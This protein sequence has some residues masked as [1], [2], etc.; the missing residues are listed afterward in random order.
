MS[1]FAKF[2]YVIFLVVGCPV[3]AVLMYENM[4]PPIPLGNSFLHEAPDLTEAELD[5]RTFDFYPYTGWHIQE[6]IHHKG[7]LKGEEQGYD[8]DLKSGSLGFFIDFDLLN[9]PEKEENEY[10][11][12]L[13]GGSGAQGWGGQSNE[14]MFYQKL[15]KKL[16][17]SPALQ[18]RKITVIN[19]AMAGS[20]SYQNFLALNK[21]GHQLEPDLIVSYS[22]V[23]DLDVPIAN[24]SDSYLRFNQLAGL[25]YLVRGSEYPASLKW[26]VSLFPRTLNRTGIGHALKMLISSNYFTELAKQRNMKTF[27]NEGL[28]IRGKV[29][30]IAIPAYADAL[31]SIKRD[32]QGIPI[33]YAL[34]AMSQSEASW[35]DVH[36]GENY[37]NNFY[38][39]VV[40]RV[41]N[42]VNSDWYFVNVH[43]KLSHR[44][45]KY[46]SL[47]LGNEG[48]TLVAEILAKKIEKIMSLK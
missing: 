22:G 41:D 30:K 17:S 33:L 32:F 26:L 1:L 31:K 16:N 10:R 23:N 13:I 27:N 5:F 8:Y 45:E 4:A 42:Y 6:N 9:P 39:S 7:P 29:D 36:L 14:K 34:Q 15:E 35:Y 38:N 43:Q 3:I 2:L 20:V 25:T 24:Q 47:H 48:H 21:W 44:T 40:S 37:Y 19:M 18:G 12:I 28:D 46:I 11:I